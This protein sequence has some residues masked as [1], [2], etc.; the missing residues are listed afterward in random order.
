MSRGGAISLLLSALALA[1]SAGA[2]DL[3][4][5][6]ALTGRSADTATLGDAV[7]FFRPA[8]PVKR[9][10]PP[11]NASMEMLHKALVPHVLAI[12][13]GTSVEF[14]NLDPI[15]HNLFSTTPGNS[16]DLGL[17]RAGHEKSVTFDHPG[18]VRVYCNVHHEMFAYI[19]VLDTP[20]FTGVNADGSFTL[21]GLP[22][23]GG[24]LVVWHPRATVWREKLV[25]PDAAPVQVKLRIVRGGIPTHFN[26]Y[27]KPY[28]GKGSGY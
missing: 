7:V 25:I 26:K 19:L 24:N 8:A 12:K 3:H 2:A 16:F 1:P 5:S 15:L 14:P 13:E 20:Y 11:R 28:A 23:G 17:Y 22:A 4:G 27:G 18:L 10:T 21:H 9:R 6:V